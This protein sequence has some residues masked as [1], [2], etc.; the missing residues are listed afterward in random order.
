MNGFRNIDI[1]KI[2]NFFTV[3]NVTTISKFMNNNYILC[4]FIIAFLISMTVF[5]GKQVKLT[6]FS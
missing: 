3:R 6:S 1:R 2:H 4:K 5:F